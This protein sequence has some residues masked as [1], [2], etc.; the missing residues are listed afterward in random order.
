MTVV[1]ILLAT[2]LVS[3]LSMIG[4]L[5]LSLQEET[6]KKASAALVAFSS[7]GLI[8]G[9]FFHLLPKAYELHGEGSLLLVVLGMDHHLSGGLP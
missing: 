7:G 6:L 1:N 3:A 2:V 8:G 4:V 5:F 9:A